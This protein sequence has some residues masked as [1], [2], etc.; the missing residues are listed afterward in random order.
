MFKNAAITI[1][2]GFIGAFLFHTLQ[3]RF[4]SQA[5]ADVQKILNVS[6]VNLVDSQGR[7]RAQLGFA[8]EGPPGFWIMDE[9]GVAR[10]SMGLYPDG[11]A[12]LGLQDKNGLMIQLMRSVGASEAPLLIFKSR[13][14]DKMITGL[15]SADATPFLL[16]YDKDNKQKIQFGTYVGP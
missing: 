9:K 13:G 8:K 1:F 5:D 4:F 7:I 12:H 11:T 14:Q 2:F 6:G 15:N 16:Y 10:I 3:F